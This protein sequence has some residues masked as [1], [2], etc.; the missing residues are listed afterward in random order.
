MMATASAV[1]FLKR[2]L[3]R[4]AADRLQNPEGAEWIRGDAKRS[5]R[6]LQHAGRNAF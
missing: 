2:V 6:K 3:K 4:V 1:T 5:F